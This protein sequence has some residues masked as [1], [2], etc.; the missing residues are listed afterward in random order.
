MARGAFRI[1]IG[2]VSVVVISLVTLWGGT[3]ARAA[4]PI[5]LPGNG[6]ASR[7]VAEATN[8]PNDYHG[9]IAKAWLTYDGTTLFATGS[10]NAWNRPG[11]I[12]IHGELWANGPDT[13]GYTKVSDQSGLT[14]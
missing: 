4:I 6:V 3:A 5:A 9:P 1:I 10:T 7:P 11:R 14:T 12:D 8:S 13:A 2:V